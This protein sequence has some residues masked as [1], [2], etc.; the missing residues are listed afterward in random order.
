MICIYLTNMYVSIMYVSCYTK[1][2]SIKWKKT[3]C[4]AF[5]L[6]F[7]RPKSSNAMYVKILNDLFQFYVAI[8]L[9]KKRIWTKAIEMVWTIL[10]Q[11]LESGLYSQLSTFPTQDIH[12]KDTGRKKNE[13]LH[14]LTDGCL[15]I[16]FVML[17]WMLYIK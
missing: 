3:L 7:K 9:Q 13:I 6:S 8:F 16:N 17:P 4:L 10:G 15:S 11:Y 5:D 14:I 12:R 2:L 1:H